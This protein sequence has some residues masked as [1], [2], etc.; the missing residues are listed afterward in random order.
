MMSQVAVFTLLL[1]EAKE[2]VSEELNV[3]DAARVSV[4]ED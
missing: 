3:T 1:S 2:M 4:C